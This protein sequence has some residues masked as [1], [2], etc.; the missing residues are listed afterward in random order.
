MDTFYNLIICLLIT[1]NSL[2]NTVKCTCIGL[3]SSWTNI[4]AF[5]FILYQVTRTSHI[6]NM[7]TKYCNC[8]FISDQ[9]QIAYLANKF[10]ECFIR[11]I[12]VWLYWRSP[13][14]CTNCLLSKLLNSSVMPNSLKTRHCCD[15]TRI[16]VSIN[17]RT[18][19]C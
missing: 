9:L 8:H 7:Y 14:N 12:I 5:I 1:N 4:L 13:S 17:K 10:I 11:A 3:L 18:K 6:H 2:H 16:R 15:T 19:N